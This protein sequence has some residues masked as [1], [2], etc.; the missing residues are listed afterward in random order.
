MQEL[1]RFSTPSSFRQRERLLT[2]WPAELM[3]RCPVRS[4]EGLW[5]DAVYI[6]PLPTLSLPGELP[7]DSP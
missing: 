5:P 3:P 7:I 1:M 6:N 4:H 2:A